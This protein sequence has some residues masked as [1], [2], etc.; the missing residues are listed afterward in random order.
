[1]YYSST[2][3]S[4]K[5]QQLRLTLAIYS[6]QLRRLQEAASWNGLVPVARVLENRPIAPPRQPIREYVFIRLARVAL[7]GDRR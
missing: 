5:L 2:A 6:C 7:V 4:A 1:M 3:I